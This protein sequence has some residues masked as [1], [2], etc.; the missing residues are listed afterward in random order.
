MNSTPPPDTDR[1]PNA[2]SDTLSVIDTRADS[3]VETIWT[4]QSPGDPFGASP[5]ALA[6]DK[7]GNESK[8]SNPAASIPVD[9]TPPDA[10]TNLTF[11]VEKRVLQLNWTPSRANDLAGYYIYRGESE[12]I[13]PRITPNAVVG[14]AYADSGYQSVGMTP[15]KTFLVSVTAVDKG[16]NESPK[17]TVTVTIPD[18]DPPLA[19]R[20]M[21]ARDARGDRCIPSPPARAVLRR[22]DRFPGADEERADRACGARHP[23]RP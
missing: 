18:D 22:S 23:L 11:K 17:V 5:N 14:S 2:A 7:S 20:A 19:P 21:A 8:R 3:V 9:K 6:F 15:G 4:R 10:P 12:K 1:H 13:Q 16:R